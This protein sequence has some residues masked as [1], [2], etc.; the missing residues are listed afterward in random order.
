MKDRYTVI[1]RAYQSVYTSAS[2]EDGG[3]EGPEWVQKG[4]KRSKAERGR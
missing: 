3:C 1:Q 2:A 4:G